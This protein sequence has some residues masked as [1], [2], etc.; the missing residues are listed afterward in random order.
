MLPLAAETAYLAFPSWRK[1]EGRAEMAVGA[2]VVSYGAG[3]GYGWGEQSRD[4]EESLGAQDLS[5][6]PHSCVL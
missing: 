6:L 1:G 4:R 2:A 5:C 3:C